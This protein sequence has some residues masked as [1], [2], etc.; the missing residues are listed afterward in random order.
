MLS[1]YKFLIVIAFYLEDDIDIEDPKEK[2]KGHPMME[3]LNRQNIRSKFQ[4]IKGKPVITNKHFFLL[5][6]SDMIFVF[7]FQIL[8]KHSPD[9]YIQFVR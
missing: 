9:C 1:G 2:T 7:L 6:L 5:V 8:Y 4:A 3:A